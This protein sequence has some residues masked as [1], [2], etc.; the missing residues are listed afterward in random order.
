M[1]QLTENQHGHL[2]T[3]TV[4]NDKHR[5]ICV[6][7][8]YVMHEKYPVELTRR[9]IVKIIVLHKLKIMVFIYYRFIVL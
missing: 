7:C 9:H 3:S 8:F 4:D 1:K 6:Q 5:R 2:T